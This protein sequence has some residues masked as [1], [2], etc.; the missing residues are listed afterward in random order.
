M[1]P[2]AMGSQMDPILFSQKGVHALDE[3]PGTHGPRLS[4]FWAAVGAVI[5][6]AVAGIA[7]LLLG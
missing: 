5:L 1:A 2:Q 4:L 3:G 6:L 7:F